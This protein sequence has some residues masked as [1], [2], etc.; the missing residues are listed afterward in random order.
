MCSTFNA[1]REA[2]QTAP[3][4]GQKNYR[5]FKI[6]FSSLHLVHVGHKSLIL[7]CITLAVGS[8]LCISIQMKVLV[9]AI[10]LFHSYSAYWWCWVCQKGSWGRKISVRYTCRSRS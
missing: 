2:N 8:A 3:D 1:N 5:W 6:S 7:V 9:R 10:T 4:N